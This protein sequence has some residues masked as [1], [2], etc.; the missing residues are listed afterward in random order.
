MAADKAM[1]PSA[2]IG[3]VKCGVFARSTVVAAQVGS[4][5]LGSVPTNAGHNLFGVL[6][7]DT[8]GAVRVA[9]PSFVWNPNG[10]ADQSVEDFHVKR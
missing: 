9:S 8:V 2:K 10:P 7:Q 4:V 5:T 6:A 3:K 1:D